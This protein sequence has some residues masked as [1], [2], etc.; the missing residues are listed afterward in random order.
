[1]QKK[2]EFE[3][4]KHSIVKF[5]IQPNKL[6]LVLIKYL[7]HWH[8]AFKKCGFYFSFGFELKPKNKIKNSK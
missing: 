3:T 1:M 2:I 6:K 5:N 8:C 7:Q 4:Q